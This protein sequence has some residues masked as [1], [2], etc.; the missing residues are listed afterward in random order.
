[1]KKKKQYL[2]FCGIDVAKNKH[3]ACL[4][5]RNGHVLSKPKSYRNDRQGVQNLIHELKQSGRAHCVLI[6]MEATGHYW[7]SLHD[8][9]TQHAYA[10]VVLNPIQTALQAKQAIRK[11][12]TDKHDAL[13]I[14]N[15]LRTGQH[16][17]AVVP[18]EL[19]MTCRQL[20]RLRYRMVR[21]MAM[22]K[23]LVHSRLHPIWPEYE[24][25]FSNTFGTTS[26]ALLKTAS[27]P[28][29]LMALD[30]EVLNEL[31]RKTSRGRFGPAQVQKIRHAAQTSVGMQRG[32]YGIS[33]SIKCLLEQIEVLTPVR[34]QLEAEI[35]QLAAQLP[36][37]LFTLPGATDLTI[38]SLYGEID[39]I[40]TFGSP[41][42]LIAFAGLDPKVFQ[43]GQY[44]APR[45]HISKRGSPHL[46]RT[47]WQMAF[48]AICH[49]GCLRDYWHRKRRQNK[50][51]TVAVTAAA[52]KLC[53]IIWRIMT[54]RRDYIPKGYSSQ[55]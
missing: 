5:D 43:T 26:M 39:P 30:P 36:A 8:V 51:H 19:A 37:Y 27:T 52:N 7:Y 15:L 10:V 29:E 9:L 40:E 33:I 54:D 53:H 25:L 23:Q 2:R 20:T 24:G 17:A 35:A 6:G 55:S 14:A 48:S 42:Q 16:K 49:E 34:E 31:I 28:K 1:M 47:L 3:V 50:H 38:V 32:Q 46:R 18:G 11:C 45:R 13:H 41:S 12:K 44:D 22:T 4:I 21:Q